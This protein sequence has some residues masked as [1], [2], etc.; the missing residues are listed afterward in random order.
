[1]KIK[2]LLKMILL[3]SIVSCANIHKIRDDVP[4]YPL[5]PRKLENINVALVL[6][7]G[8]VK[9]IAH[10]G[11][12]EVLEENNIPIDLI[13]G[14]SAGSIIGAMYADRP[15]AYALKQ[16]FVKFKRT[17]LIQPRYLEIVKFPF[18]TFGI[19]DGVMLEKYLK[20]SIKARNFEDLKIPLVVVTTNL[21]TNESF[22]ISSGPITPAV[23]ASSAIP[24]VFSPIHAYGQVLSDG[25]IIEAVPTNSA[26]YYK[27]KMIIAVNVAAPP[28]KGKYINMLDLTYRALWISYY[29]LSVLQA[30]EA[31]INLHPDL[32]NIGIFDDSL[33]NEIYLQGKLEALRNI[34]LIKAQ[35]KKLGISFKKPIKSQ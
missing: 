6:G 10:L 8:G 31:H 7:G 24:P 29:N 19:E 32:E 22:P 21:K 12:L 3:F 35:M 17:N 26:K 15:D 11:V 23:H 9:G 27:P 13:V 33:K 1:M 30:K 2:S 20:K 16:E 25:G 5:P 18:S 4:N 28:P 14:T 34:E